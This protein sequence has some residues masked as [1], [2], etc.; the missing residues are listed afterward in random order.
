MDVRD[1]RNYAAAELFRLTGQARWH[2]VF[3]E[4][5]M[6]NKPDAVLYLWQSHEQRHGAWAYVSIKLLLEHETGG[7]PG[8]EAYNVIGNITID[9]SP[10]DAIVIISNF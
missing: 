2:E 8:I 1:M 9:E 5:T 10:D 3:L 7:E 6:L 4:T